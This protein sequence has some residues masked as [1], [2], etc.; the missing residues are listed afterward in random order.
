MYLFETFASHKHLFRGRVQLAG[1]PY[2]EI[3]EDQ[4]KEKRKVWI[5]PLRLMDGETYVPEE[6]IRSKQECNQ[7]KQKD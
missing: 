5:F 3:Q 1:I 2:Q 6:V 4:E 7:K